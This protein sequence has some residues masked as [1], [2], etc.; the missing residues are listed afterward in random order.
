MRPL[1]GWLSRQI[2]TLPLWRFPDTWME[3]FGNVLS[4]WATF[5]MNKYTSALAISRYANGSFWKCAIHMGDSPD[6]QIHFH[7]GDFPMSKCTSMWATN[8]WTNTLPRWWFYDE[9]CT[10]TWT[11]YRWANNPI[12]TRRNQKRKQ[13]FC[14]L[15]FL[16]PAKPYRHFLLICLFLAIICMG[17]S[18]VVC[19]SKGGFGPP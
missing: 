1:H 3:V 17:G 11:T 7:F 12:R 18:K 13:M 8:R 2:N 15:L 10:S 16:V 6:E 19:S 14:V 9:Q 5:P 4:A